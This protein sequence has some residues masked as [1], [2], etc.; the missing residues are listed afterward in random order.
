MVNWFND[1]YRY[2]HANPSKFQLIIFGTSLQTGTAKVTDDIVI[3][4]RSSVKLLGTFLDSKLRFNEHVSS[5]YCKAGNTVNALAL[6]SRTL[7]SVTKLALVRYCISC[8]FN[9]CPLI[10]H[11]CGDEC[12]KA[13]ERIQ[14]LNL[15]IMNL[16]RHT[17]K[18]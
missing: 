14:L 12:S 18:Y 1:N 13:L 9:Y 3:E 6:V 10:C 11:F 4:L 7:D 17:P 5:L 15:Y 16:S 8:Y 2:M